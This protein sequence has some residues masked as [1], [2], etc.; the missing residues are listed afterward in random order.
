MTNVC[1]PGAAPR[2]TKWSHKRVH[3]RLP[4][5]YGTAGAIPGSAAH[6]LVLRYALDTPLTG[7]ALQVQS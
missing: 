4:T 7:G 2:A 5:R 6:H 1:L 3:A